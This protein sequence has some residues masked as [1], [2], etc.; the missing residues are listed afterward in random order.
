MWDVRNGSTLITDMMWIKFK[1]VF[2]C[3]KDAFLIKLGCLICRYFFLNWCFLTTQKRKGAVVSNFT[4]K[5]KK[6]PTTTRMH[7]SA[8]LDFSS[9]G[10]KWQLNDILKYATEDIWGEI[11]GFRVSRH[12]LRERSDVCALC[13][14][15]GGH[16]KI[17]HFA[18]SAHVVMLWS[19]LKISKVSL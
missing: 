9:S 8:Q 2:H 16:T 5:V 15:G 1:G 18:L 4:Q 12:D 6:N 7:C 14:R 3:R 10:S 11:Q 13:V 19:W 17:V